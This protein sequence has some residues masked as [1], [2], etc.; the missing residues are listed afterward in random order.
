VNKPVSTARR[1]SIDLKSIPGIRRRTIP[2]QLELQLA[3]LVKEPPA[4]DEWLHEQKFDGY[5]M[6]CRLDAGE[7]RFISRN[8]QDWTH[9][10]KS[11]VAPVLKLP[12]RRAL[13]DGEVVVLDKHGV[14]SFQNLQNAFR[15]GRTNPLVYFVFDLIYLDDYDL[16]GVTLENRKQVLKS[17]IDRSPAAGDHLRF[18]DHLVGTA[19]ELRDRMCAMGLEGM[20]SKRRDSLYAAGR[21][22]TWLKSKCRQEQEFV[23][24]GFTDPAGARAG[25]GAL[26]LGYYR[27]RELVYAGRVGTGFNERLLR[28]LLKKLKSLEQSKSPFV[29]IP[30]GASTGRLHFVR[31]KLVAQIEFNNWT[32]D[33]LLRQAA[34]LGLREDKSAREVRREAPLPN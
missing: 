13:V 27:N 8:Q 2:K 10:L 7:A 32:D 22:N 26:L 29:S 24:G 30:R 1:R 17:L 16:T 25:F 11:L 15:E 5:R 19:A 3:T 4:G 33:G 31:P 23:I 20:I 14:S 9:K 34:F 12:V 28:D 21:T 6:L 18:S